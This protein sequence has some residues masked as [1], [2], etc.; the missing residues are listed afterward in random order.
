MSIYLNL[1]KNIETKSSKIAIWGCGFVGT[2]NLF[3]LAK[4][5]FTCLG[6]D[7]NKQRINELKNGRYNINSDMDILGQMSQEEIDRIKYTYD[8]T[9]ENIKEY[10]IHMLCLPTEKDFKPYDGYVRDVITSIGKSGSK[11]FLLIIECSMPPKWIGTSIIALLKEYGLQ[12]NIHYLLG[13]A[14]RRDLFGDDKFSLKNT[15]R[16]IA[17]NN[18]DGSKIMYTLYHNFCDELIIAK[19][20][21][22]VVLSKIIENTYRCFDISLANQLNVALRDYDITHVLEL[23]STKWNVEKY[24]PSFG[25]GGYCI[26]LAPQYIM[27]ELD[28]NFENMPVF[29]EVLSFNQNSVT[30]VLNL[31]S[32]IFLYAKSIVVSVCRLLKP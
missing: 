17:G 4:S 28:N 32:S 10:D 24:H 12:E 26:P 14:P 13:A 29:K 1:L 19:D 20:T 6:I 7:T 21:Y 11:D 22:H 15:P 5:G 3:Y 25:I 8:Y 2:T 9:K 23:A 18:E 27:E 31:Y 16:V 30:K